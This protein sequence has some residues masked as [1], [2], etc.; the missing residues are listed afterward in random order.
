[1][2]PPDTDLKT[3]RRRHGP[4]IWGMVAAVALALVLWIASTRPA[5]DPDQPTLAAPPAETEESGGR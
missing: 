4:A 5:E 1:M 3:Q 2:T